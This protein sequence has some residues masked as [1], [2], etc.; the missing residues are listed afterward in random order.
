MLEAHGEKHTY[1]SGNG[2]GEA[3]YKRDVMRDLEVRNLVEEKQISV[4][5][6]KT[7]ADLP[8]PPH[9]LF[10]AISHLAFTEG[11]YLL[12]TRGLAVLQSDA[13]AHLL[14]QPLVFHT[15]HL[16]DQRVLWMSKMNKSVATKHLSLEPHRIDS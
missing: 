7:F 14:P 5:K 16:Q 4:S 1:L 9:P 2:Q 8:P 3:V 13:G 11:F 12:R 6:L 15:N 10:K